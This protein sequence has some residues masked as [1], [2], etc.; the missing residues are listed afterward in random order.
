MGH[1]ILVVEDSLVDYEIVTRCLQ[2]AG[3][4]FPVRLC[5]DGDM[6][7]DL[8]VERKGDFAEFGYPSLILLDLNLPGT[9]GRGVLKQLKD[10]DDTKNIP[11]IILTTSNNANDVEACYDIGANSYLQKPTVPEDY[12][13][14]AHAVKSF[15]FDWAHLPEVV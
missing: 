2:K 12:V 3:L 5:A 9:D 11:V 15:W 7:L 1:Y 4:D 6:A 10:C 13:A 8:L 14:M